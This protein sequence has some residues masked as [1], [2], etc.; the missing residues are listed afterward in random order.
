MSSSMV[1]DASF[2]NGVFVPDKPVAGGRQSQKVRL[3]VLID[4]DLT[5]PL[6][7]ALESECIWPPYDL[8]R[9]GEPRS[10]EVEWVGTR[11]PDPAFVGELG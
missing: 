6:P 11:M 2:E 4:E 5:T 3:S 7:N 1:I 8:P 10:V 9:D